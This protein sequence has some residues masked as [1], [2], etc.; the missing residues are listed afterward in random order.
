MKL[1]P[2]K[3]L[4]D[5]VAVI[6]NGLSVPALEQA[7]LATLR[8]FCRRSG[9]YIERLPAL[10][11]YPGKDTYYLDPQPYGRVLYI[12]RVV[13]MLPD[14]ETGRQLPLLNEDYFAHNNDSLGT[15]SVS[16]SLAYGSAATMPTRIYTNSRESGVIRVWPEPTVQ[17]DD[18][19]YVTVSMTYK[20][21]V[22][23][24]TGELELP[25]VFFRYWFDVLLAGTVYKLSMQMDKPWTSR[26]N[27]AFYGKL[28]MS[29]CANAR[30]EARAG[31]SVSEPPFYYPFWA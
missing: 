14:E 23:S 20:R 17:V 27:A 1:V 8:E 4:Y 18:C 19:L 13:Y 6:C 12:N 30:T 3:D 15:D 7:V 31:H 28:F 22:C 29:G 10:T 21:E 2:L 24:A 9:A 16:R 11:L 26:E 25:E 5:E